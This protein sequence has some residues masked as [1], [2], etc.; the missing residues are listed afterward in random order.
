[1]AVILGDVA[2]H[3]HEALK[4]ATLAR[5]TL[6]AFMK[7]T[8][9]PRT[10]LRLAGHALSDPD[11]GQLVTVAIALFDARRGT[12]TYAL[13]GHPPPI[14]LGVARPDAPSSCSSPPLGLDMPT[15][16]R[17]R[18]IS[19]TAGERACFFSDGLIEAR[20]SAPGS[21]H[22]DLFGRDRV[23]ELFATLPAEAGAEELLQ[24]IREE[25]DA[26]PDDMAACIL[27]PGPPTGQAPIDHEELEVDR[28]AI[29]GGHVREYL[30]GSGL[31]GTEAT[32]LLTVAAGRL[33]HADTVMLEIDRSTKTTRARIASGAPEPER[34]TGIHG[35]PAL[36][37]A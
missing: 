26:T 9:E 1:V 12:L 28:P 14:L 6:R 27:T 30:L 5:Y 20:R 13:A 4:H 23:A 18:T 25:A 10:A 36:Q 34:P 37:R 7:E 22:P 35:A 11:S 2:G 16:R 21:D 17:Q 8:R 15:G 29:E 3:G 31:T 32:R 19:L 33:E 24:A